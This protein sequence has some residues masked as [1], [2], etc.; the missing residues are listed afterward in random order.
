MRI[1]ALILLLATAAWAQV[2]E[3]CGQGFSLGFN[4]GDSRLTIF[5]SSGRQTNEIDV[6]AG[7]TGPLVHLSDVAISKQGA[8]AA[9]GSWSATNA[10]HVLLDH[11]GRIANTVDTWPFIPARLV[12]GPD[13]VIW[14]YGGEQPELRRYSAA[15]EH[16]GSATLPAAA[17]HAPTYLGASNMA[18]G[19]WFRDTS[20][21]LEFDPGARLTVE[22]ALAP[23]PVL[24]ARV[25]LTDANE[26]YG[27]SGQSLYFFNR[28]ET[29]WLPA[30]EVL[31]TPIPAILLGSHGP[32]L[33][34]RTDTRRLVSL[35]H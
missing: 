10:G 9:A 18:V 22:I 31:P 29:Q 20:R 2:E 35:P 15:G 21:W 7:V 19:L 3:R 17:P 11:Q 23:P 14:I 5:D 12:F 26:I 28:R 8:L 1:A 16:L 27:G 32:R 33:I 13:G 34:L 30:T 24:E 4:P 25:I 6:T